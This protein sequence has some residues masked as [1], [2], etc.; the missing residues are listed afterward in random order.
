MTANKLVD[1]PGS[2]AESKVDSV[3]C[4]IACPPQG[5][6]LAGSFYW[7]CG[8]DLDVELYLGTF[9]IGHMRRK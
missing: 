6:G 9:S 5:L 1:A 8:N 3:A 7:F 2:S 4:A